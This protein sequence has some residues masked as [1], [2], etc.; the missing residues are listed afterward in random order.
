M[1]KA[2]RPLEA[3]PVMAAAHTLPNRRAVPVALAESFAYCRS[4]TRRRAGNFYFSFLT[5]PR[6]R[7]RAMCALYGFMRLCDDIGD[8]PHSSPA[9]KRAQLTHWRHALEE[10]LEGSCAAHPVFPALVQTVRRYDIPPEYLRDVIAGVQTDLTCT[11]FETFDEL[12]QY[13][14]QV[15]GAVGLCCL[16]IWGFHDERA[17]PRAVDCGTAFQLT[18]I[19]RDVGEDAAMGRLYLPRA[20]LRRFDLA[21]EEL[22]K[23]HPSEPFREL[24]RFEVQRARQYYGKARQLFEWV[25]RPGHPIL[26]AMLRIYGGLLDEIERRDYNV[27]THRVRLSRW[28][29]M[30]IVIGSIVRHRL[31]HRRIRPEKNGSAEHSS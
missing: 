16:H 19:L 31:L 11:G 10:A 26:D 2:V 12:R 24:M 25:D 23:G 29:K 1:E 3:R 6:E 9:R 5:L 14:Y 22:H 21:E 17:I 18:N 15:A 8:D 20:D 30:Q 4:L 7:F 28:K 13:C 27:F